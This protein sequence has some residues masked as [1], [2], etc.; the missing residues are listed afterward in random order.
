MEEINIISLIQEIVDA[1]RYK[2]IAVD[3]LELE[4]QLRLPI[5]NILNYI[6]FKTENNSTKVKVLKYRYSHKRVLDYVL[7][8][9][10]NQSFCYTHKDY[11]FYMSGLAFLDF[12]EIWVDKKYKDLETEH[13]VIL[14]LDILNSFVRALLYNNEKPEDKIG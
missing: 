9:L 5:Y 2:H 8:S 10:S 11:N 12:N 4:E 6:Y 3:Y 13:L 7:A 1:I 14:E